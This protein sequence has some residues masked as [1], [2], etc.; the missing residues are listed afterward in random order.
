[1]SIEWGA[2]AGLIAPDDTTFAYLE[3]RPGVQ[4]DFDEYVERWSRYALRPRR[5]ASTPRCA[6]TPP[7][8]RRR[9]RGAPTPARRCRSRAGVPEPRDEGEQRALEYM[10][11]TAGHADAGHRDRPR[12]HRQLHQ[13]PPRRPARGRRDRA[14][15]AVAAG[16]HALVVP[17][18]MAVKRAAEAEGLDRVFI[19]AGF[20]WRNAGC[21]MC[22][23]MNPDVASPRRAGRLDQQSQLRGPSGPW[24][25]HAPDGPRDGSRRRDHG[26]PHR[27]AHARTKPSDGLARAVRV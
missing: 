14:R 2:R 18:S 8:S 11:L 13:Q 27:R 20:E 23:G 9:S 3:G 22:L 7:R 25:P 16:V 21:S 12:L 4:G 10:G 15:R 19:D 1:M 5:A 17:G 24:R 6:S 26:P